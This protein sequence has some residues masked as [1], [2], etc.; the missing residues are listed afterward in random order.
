[1]SRTTLFSAFAVDRVDADSGMIHGV[2]VITLGAA[3]GHGL[4]IDSTTLEQV[5]DCAATYKGG[6][7]VKVDHDGGAGDIAGFLT[8]FRVEGQK[9]LADLQLLAASPHRAYV[10]EL[11]S[12]IPDTFGLSINF[13]GVPEVRDGKRFARCAEIYSV[14]LVD[15]PAANPSGLFS[16]GG[17][18]PKTT[19]PISKMEDVKKEDP[20]AAL[21]AALAAFGARVSALEAVIAAPKQ[22]EKKDEAMAAL[23][24]KTVLAQFTSQFGEPT[25]PAAQVEAKQPEAKAF[26]A[27]VADR[28]ASAK[29]SKAA[30]I[31]WA[32]TNHPAEHQA[33]LALPADKQTL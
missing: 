18:Q 29:C 14:D 11:A 10:L 13:S 9:L 3:R 23:V 16:E 6:V 8:G 21:S 19:E 5:R 7:K 32:I 27:I 28:L 33:F 26:N 1:M 20:I 22:D 25:K 17:D 2:S 4:S 24:A 30:A 15:E 31:H 12:K